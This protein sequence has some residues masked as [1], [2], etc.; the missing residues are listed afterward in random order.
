MIPIEKY[1]LRRTEHIF[2]IPFRFLFPVNKTD[3]KI[4]STFIK[5]GKYVLPAVIM[6]FT[7]LTFVS[8]DQ[9][10]NVETVYKGTIQGVVCDS[11][12]RAP[13]EQVKNYANGIPDTVYSDAAGVFKFRNISMPRSEYWYTIVTTKQGYDTVLSSIMA[14]LDETRYLDTVYLTYLRK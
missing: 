11:A 6:L 13:L 5:N 2:C 7:M 10:S 4:K 3:F 12:T 8:C 14:K 9:A 1:K